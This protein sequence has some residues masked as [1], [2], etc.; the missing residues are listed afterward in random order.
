MSFARSGILIF[1]FLA[2]VVLRA[3]TTVP[4]ASS[5]LPAQTLSPGGAS[6]T[7]NL[8]NHFILPGVTGQIAQ[9]DTVLGKVNIE[10]R[11]DVAPRHV[12]NF[13]AYA[14]SAAY[15]NSFIHRSASLESG[16]GP[17]SIVQGGGY[18]SDGG[19]NVSAIPKLT[20]VPLEYNLPNSR[21]TLAAA[22]TSDINSATSEWY[23]NV[24]DNS[25]ILGPT[26]GG[27]YTV[28]GRVIGNGMTVIDRIAALQVSNLGSPFT[29][30][31]LRDYNGSNLSPA[32]LIIVNTITTATIYP[33]ATADPAVLSFSASSANP[34]I[35]T[36]TVSGS[37]LTLSSGAGGTA[38]VI[39]TATDTN[40]SSTSQTVLVTVIGE[41]V[42]RAPTITSQ[43]QP[44]ITL[45]SGT[46]NTVVFSVAATGAPPLTYQWRRNRA[47]IAGQLSPTYVRLNTSDADAGSYTCVVTNSEG[48]VESQL[49]TLFFVPS[50]AADRGRLINLSILSGLAANETM[51]MGTVLGGVGTS[52]SKGLLARAAGP[53]LTQLGVTG[54]LPD[55]QMS[56]VRVNGGSVVASNNDWAGT[57]ALANAFAQVGAFNYASANSKDAAIFQPSLALG[58]YT[59]RVSDASGGAGLAIAELYDSTPASA[60]VATTPRLI[61]VSVLK[62]ISEGSALTSGFVIGGTTAKTVLVRAIGP[63]LADFGVTETMSDPQ[64]TLFNSSS[65]KIA[66]NDNWGG[67]AQIAKAAS[68]VGAFAIGNPAS[69]DAVLLITLAPGNYS[70]QVSGKSGGGTALVEVY[71]VP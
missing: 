37:S 60:F 33:D 65:V 10:L 17:I 53:A 56:L 32:N 47:A 42:A 45:A 66:E 3:Q 41:A 64:L 39:V 36:A 5:V 16:G 18:R 15:S 13:L 48:S 69:N 35:V 51:T 27:G 62:Q 26:N 22:R 50:G 28:F 70:A 20:A 49:S 14:Q 31:P 9:F 6:V 24:R 19:T 7:L 4:T 25:T 29:D 55:P 46:V 12:A 68:S 57:A 34:A 11:A 67:D 71:E 52:G 23:V 54:V 58:D 21:G 40:G 44:L 63:T 61:T 43:P 38:N 59:V 1:T 30:L 8:R 2:S